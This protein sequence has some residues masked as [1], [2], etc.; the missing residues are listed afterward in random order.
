MAF[1]Q[2]QG[3]K[4]P[5]NGCFL[6]FD[7]G[8]KMFDT[9][10][11][12]FLCQALTCRSSANIEDSGNMIE[13]HHLHDI[14]VIPHHIDNSC[15]VPFCF[16]KSPASSPGG[17]MNCNQQAMS[18]PIIH[19]NMILEWVPDHLIYLI[20]LEIKMPLVLDSSLVQDLRSLVRSQVL[21]PKKKK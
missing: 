6:P 14:K 5:F 4:L 16:G 12:F 13:N 1:S 20:L 19:S 3:L 21:A 7:I 9:N 11:S 17:L 10:L 18:S 15:R 2:C 8:A